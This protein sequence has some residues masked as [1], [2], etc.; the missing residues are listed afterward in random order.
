MRSNFSSEAL[1][2][3]SEIII[4][5]KHKELYTMRLPVLK[6]SIEN[7]DYHDFVTFCSTPL[8]DYNEFYGLKLKSRFALFKLYREQGDKKLVENL[9]KYF[10]FYM[11]GFHE[12]DDILY[13]GSRVLTKDLFDL[14]CDYIAIAVGY[15]NIK[16]LKLVITEDMDEVTKRQIMLERKIAA[17]KSKSEDGAKR[18]QSFDIIMTGVCQEYGFKYQD[19]YNMTPYSILFMYSQLGAIMNYNITNIAAGNGLLKKSAKHK[20]WAD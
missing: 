17:T 9:M 1:L 3:N 7:L 12:K 10:T 4:E 14:F 20:H 13:W 5:G 15:K 2:C 11:I 16:D 19:L 18:N 8:K 6:D